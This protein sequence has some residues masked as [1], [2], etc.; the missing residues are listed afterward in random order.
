MKSSLKNALILAVIWSIGLFAVNQ[1]VVKQ[2]D[3]FPVVHYEKVERVGYN[4]VPAEWK[5][6]ISP[7]L[8]FEKVSEEPSRKLTSSFGVVLLA[9]GFIWLILLGAEVVEFKKNFIAEGVL[10]ALLLGYLVCQYS[11]YSNVLVNNSVTVS[12]ADFQKMTGVTDKTVKYVTD[13]EN[14]DIEKLF[15]KPII[16]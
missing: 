4:A 3:K 2:D 6:D 7:K 8:A 13:N 14:K 11:T 9:L 12:E 15:D 16:K 1:F 5:I 10:F